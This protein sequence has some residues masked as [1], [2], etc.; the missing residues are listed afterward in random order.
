MSLC[1]LVSG[2]KYIVSAS[3]DRL[4]KYS[5]RPE[6]PMGGPMRS[7]VPNVTSGPVN[8]GT[9]VA[10]QISARPFLSAP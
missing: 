8:S 9:Y 2:T 4:G 1:E 6:M 3:V 7:G 10:S 5:A